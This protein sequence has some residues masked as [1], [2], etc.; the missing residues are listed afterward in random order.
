MIIDMRTYT[1]VTGSVQR[2]LDLYEKEGLEI[3][4]G[5]L[6][7]L[8]GYYTTTTGELHQIVHMWGYS[9]PVDRDIRR[10]RLWAD[11]GFNAFAQKALPL[12]VKQHNV[13]LAPTNFSPIR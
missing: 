6:G 10:A 7:N 13:L 4:K 12:I 5:I 1:L 9:D 11:P 8:V 3:Q 2:Y